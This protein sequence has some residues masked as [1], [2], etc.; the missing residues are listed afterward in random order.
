MRSRAFRRL[1]PGTR[2]SLPI[3]DAF[4]T[5]RAER[6]IR[7]RLLQ[8]CPDCIEYP[9]RRSL[10]YR[11]ARDRERKIGIE[12]LLQDLTRLIRIL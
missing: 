11:I 1:F 12:I 4:P 10:R 8:V 3:R 9:E 5:R 6:R 2:A 7:A